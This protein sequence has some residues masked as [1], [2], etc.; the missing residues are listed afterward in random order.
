VIPAGGIFTG[1]D[2]AASS[3]TAR[4][5]CRWPR[6]SRW[7]KECGLPERRQ[8][9]VL[10]G[11]RRRHRGQPDLA[12]RL[13]DAHA[14]EQPGIGDGIRPNCEAYGYL[15]DANGKCAYVDRLQPRGGAHPGRKKVGDGQDLSVHPHA[16]LRLLD[17]RPL[18]Y[19]LK[20]TTRRSADGSYQQ[21]C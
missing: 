6:A 1:S 12:H 3:K 20:D 13:P 16:Q 7:P 17:L 4:P 18:T 5:P 21:D 19:R 15:L 2:A 11:R 14:E 10:Q 8:A 9:G